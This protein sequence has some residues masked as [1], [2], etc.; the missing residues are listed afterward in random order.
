MVSHTSFLLK[1][2]WSDQAEFERWLSSFDVPFPIVVE[3]KISRML[4]HL[5]KQH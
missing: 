4:S 1:C 2:A 3:A 5:V